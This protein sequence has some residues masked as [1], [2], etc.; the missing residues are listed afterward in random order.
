MPV[1]E[2]KETFKEFIMGYLREASKPSSGVPK[3][4]MLVAVK[5]QYPELT[6]DSEECFPGCE[7]R[8]PRWRHDFDR[9]LYDLTA[10]RPA[11]I[12]SASRG[13]Y[14]LGPGAKK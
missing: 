3:A 2:R 5:E 1:S 11:L 14:T 4:D 10:R 12:V 6:D 13:Y 7:G 9:S 8:H